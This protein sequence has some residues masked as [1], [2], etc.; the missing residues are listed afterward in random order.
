MTVFGKVRSMP[1]TVSV[2][3]PTYNAPTLLRAT[4]DSV[5][6]QTFADFEVV[7]IDDGSTDDTPQVLAAI[8]DPRLR[9]V[10]QPNAGI[11]HA[12]NRGIDESR[13]AYV[14]L[15]DHDDVWHPDKLA[16]QVAFL[17]ANA[18][19]AGCCTLWERTD[20]PGV[21]IV[22]KAQ[23]CDAR[24]FVRN[25][26]ATLATGCDFLIT[27]CICF[28]RARGRG[29]R[30]ATRKR[31]VE[32]TPFQLG[33]FARG[34][35][36]IAGDSILMTYRVHPTNYSKQAAFFYNGQRMMRELWRAG[37]FDDLPPEQQRAL[38]GLLAYSGRTA[39]G[40]ALSAGERRVAARTYARELLHQLRDGRWKYALAVPPLLVAPTSWSRRAFAAV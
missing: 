10:R 16:E 29:L 28:D 5:F 18:D 4:L 24:G 39:T 37:Q 38:P 32:D 36:G 40:R 33:L 25:P 11:G 1:P 20:R 2:V 26:I 22:G 35:F 30:Y 7:V 14:A 34:P 12:R 31:C 3:V 27:S 19:C 17:R 6:A 8:T 13:G 21:P 9:V 23:I 15:L